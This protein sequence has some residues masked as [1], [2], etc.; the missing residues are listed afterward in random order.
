KNL[1]VEFPLVLISDKKSDQKI[2]RRNYI[3][4]NL[5]VEFPLVLISDKKSDKKRLRCNYMAK[6][7]D[8]NFPLV[9]TS[10]KKCN[11]KRK[12]CI[13]FERRRRKNKTTIIKDI[14]NKL[15][16]LTN[17]EKNLSKLTVLKNALKF[18]EK[19][20]QDMQRILNENEILRKEKNLY[21]NYIIQ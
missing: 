18:I 7:L 16:D 4:K 15:P 9:L 3:G 8:V 17:I 10:N 1:D 5:D 14:A 13:E 2:L 20:N 12:L 21:L 11:Q 6:N 19:S